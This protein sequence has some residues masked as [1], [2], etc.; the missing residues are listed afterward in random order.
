[1]RAAVLLAFTACVPSTRSV[2]HALLDEGY[3]EIH[4]LGWAPSCAPDR[5]A[6]FEATGPAGEVVTGEVCCSRTEYDC[7]VLIA[8]V[9]PPP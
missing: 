8:R 7:R 1:M 6:L 5:G 9:S 4:V 2:Q 3:D